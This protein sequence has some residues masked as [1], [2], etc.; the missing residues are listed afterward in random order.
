MPQQDHDTSE[1]NE[2]LKILDMVFVA[3]HESSEVVKP[4][5][6]AF[7][8]PAALV[9]TKLAPVLG[10]DFA[11][12]PVGGDQIDLPIAVKVFGEFVAVVGF[13]PDQSFG[14]LRRESLAQRL[15]HQ[16]HFVRNR[17]TNPTFSENNDEP[18]LRRE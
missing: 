18:M 17:P 4:R 9:A 6:E 3:D 10:F 11:V 7:H 16:S 13:I 15:L 14:V 8:F 5:E 2:S 1:M 12:A